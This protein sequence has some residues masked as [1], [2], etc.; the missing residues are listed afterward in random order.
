MRSPGLRIVVDILVQKASGQFIYAATVLK[1]VGEEYYRPNKQLNI[2]LQPT[3]R[4]ST[5]GPDLD[6]LHTPNFIA[7]STSSFSLILV[8]IFTFHCL[9]LPDVIEDIFHME[10]NEVNLVLRSLRSLVRIPGIEC[11]RSQHKEP[12]G[13][14]DKGLRIVSCLVPRFPRR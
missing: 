9:Q 10:R 2:A 13:E 8:T 1:F 7:L 5:A 11:R 12:E 14:D 4:R 6:A 3:P